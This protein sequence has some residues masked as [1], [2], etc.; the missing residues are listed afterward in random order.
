[1]TTPTPDPALDTYAIASRV[2]YELLGRRWVWPQM[3]VVDA[4]PC[5][6][7]LFLTGRP[8]IQINSVL[9]PDGSL[10]TEGVDYTLYGGFRI[11]FS[12]AT[13]SRFSIG[14][15]RKMRN[16]GMGYGGYYPG[17]SGDPFSLIDTCVTKEFTVDYVY[18]SQ[19]NENIRFAIYM[20]QKE[21][22]LAIA[23]SEDCKLPQRVTNIARQGISMTI[24]DPQDFLEKGL[25]GVAEV[26]SVL[27][28]FNPAKA[29]ARA[30]LF[31]DSHPPA[32]RLSAVALSDESAFTDGGGADSA[33]DFADA[34]GSGS[35]YD[36]DDGG[37]A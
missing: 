12:P 13:L 26:D 25:T 8:V 17:F 37:H 1:M 23:G 31:T 20:Y 9:G 21:L 7:D 34:G 6:R 18:G 11:R 28:A 33:F 10:L 36:Y 15:A 14:V 16:Y 2:V 35:S 27:N 3:N 5:N 19:P 24:L 32:R 4:Y 29:K 22:D 30:R